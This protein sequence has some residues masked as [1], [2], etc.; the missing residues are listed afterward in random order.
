MC[1]ATCHAIVRKILISSTLVSGAFKT[2][3]GAPVVDSTKI[4]ARR[5]T[6]RAIVAMNPHNLDL[7]SQIHKALDEHQESGRQFEPVNTYSGRRMTHSSTTQQTSGSSRLYNMQSKGKAIKTISNLPVVS[8]ARA[9][10]SKICCKIT[11]RHARRKHFFS[12]LYHPL[13]YKKKSVG[14]T[15]DVPNHRGLVSES[16]DQYPLINHTHY[17]TAGFK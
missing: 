4:S 13:F 2:V 17:K 9:S 15:Q 8:A 1:L 7:H 12:P 11:S 6:I 14:P 16:Q 10:G 5:C 3:G